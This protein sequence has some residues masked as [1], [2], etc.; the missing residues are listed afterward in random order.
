M[1]HANKT[2]RDDQQTLIAK[3]EREYR[4]NGWKPVG[5][6]EGQKHPTHRD[7]Q[8]IDEPLQPWHKNIG[9]Q[10]GSVS[11][12]L[13]DV[14]L[15][16]DEA[17]ALA[18]FFLPDT[19]AVF[20]RQSTP[21]AHWLYYSDAWK[22]AEKVALVFDDPV[23][24]NSGGEP[25]E[26]GVRLVEL[27]T[28]RGE[29]E[30]IKGAQTMFP[31][32]IHPKS[33]QRVRWD[34]D[35]KPTQVEAGVLRQSVATLAAATAFVRHYPE[36]GARHEAALVLGGWLARGGWDE[37]RIE[38]FVEAIA[39]TAGDAEW[40]ER[41]RSATSA[42]GKLANGE[43]MPGAP[44][45]C[46]VF[47]DKLVTVIAGWLHLA[48]P[49]GSEQHH[50]NVSS[51]SWD[52]PDLSI[53]DDRRGELPAF[54]LDTLRPDW[55]RDWVARAAHGT[56]TNIDHVA[57]PL[58]G[59]VS[60]V[61]GG[62]RRVQPSLS[63]S[64][65]M[66]LWTG[67][68]GHSG[69]GKT[70]GLDATRLPLAQLEYERK[71]E[72]EEQRR[73]HAERAHLAALAHKKWEAAVK[74]AISHNR[75]PP[76][77]PSEADD[78][79]DWVPPRL[80]ISDITVERIGALLQAQPRGLL[81]LIDELAGWFHN[82]SRYSGG[83]DNQFWLM[84]WDG[85]PYVVERMG[86]PPV[87]LRQLIVGVLGG[88]QPDKLAD[89]FEGAAD[90]MYAR[91]LFA[92]PEAAP[93]RPLTDQ[94]DQVDR[95]ILTTLDK[96]ARL[97]DAPLRPVLLTQRAKKQF[98]ALR[99]RVST[100]A[101]LLDGRE[102]EWW[103]KVPSQVLRLAGTL[104]FLD[105][106]IRRNGQAPEYILV[107]FM[108]A[109][110]KLMVDY[111]FP[112]SCAALR[113]IGITQQH[114]DARRVLLWIRAND[115]KRVAAEEVRRGALRRGRTADETHEVLAA[116]VRAGWLRRVETKTGG[117]SVVRWDVNPKVFEVK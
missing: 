25:A 84:A 2:F 48:S 56:G 66:T 111:F 8:K 58:L 91:F 108:N 82:M 55:L 40:Q 16:C 14:D 77:R 86:R 50:D 69:T 90:G 61:I 9:V 87:S 99:K 1:T 78:P 102:R 73:A 4:A 71:D 35:G 59:I 105:W 103:T 15:D 34:R 27:R 28:G 19:D 41:V 67:I 54:P 44:R 39:R 51:F 32:S 79:G 57:V 17:R 6:E 80:F 96:L 20:G 109:A 23:S 83:K 60:S 26:H 10:F 46:E 37:N 112:H 100:E 22:T 110:I 12:G 7:W 24:T 29:P 106:G 74:E 3:A 107:Q 115:V 76:P 36:A 114:A 97:H 47:G 117:R 113:Q 95:T 85:R 42:V 70:P 72:I 94:A 33:G 65:P 68:I 104:T 43:P 5:I 63:W 116:L 11:N 81:L 18:S 92:W 13:C 21:E 53:L 45:M 38:R 31:P 75:K 49:S 88:M 93:Y 89:V 98:E 64:E 62:A 52:E 30:E 101:N